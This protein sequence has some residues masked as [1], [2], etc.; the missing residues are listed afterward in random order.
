M[1]RPFGGGLFVY[2]GWGYATLEML[3]G[4]QSNTGFAL[5]NRYQRTPINIGR[6][7]VNCAN[8]YTADL[9]GPKNEDLPAGESIGDYDFVV[10]E[11]VYTRRSIL[12]CI[13]KACFLDSP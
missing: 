10:L 9:V 5:I 3:Q 7:Q 11:Y 12:I 1:G 6:E 8:H 13:K 4:K 2:G